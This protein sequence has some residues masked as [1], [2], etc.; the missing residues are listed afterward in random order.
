MGMFD[1][2]VFDKAYTCTQCGAEV[3]S[4][5]TK[6]FERT[7]SHYHVKDCISHA[8]DIR[9]VKEEL[10]CGKCSK[11]EGQYVYIAVVRGILVGV[12]DTLE[13]AQGMLNDLNLEKMILWHHD[14]YKKYRQELGRKTRA[15]NFMRNTVN[16]FEKEYHKLGEGDEAKK[17]HLLF[18]LNK[19]YLAEAQEPLEAIKKYLAAN[20]KEDEEEGF[21]F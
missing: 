17:R 8:E 4:T 7:L 12:A 10:Y 19:D 11:F 6:A 16:W 15:L 13:A 5:Q 20:E 3:A 18:I 1:T 2:I 14:L 9:I 21:F